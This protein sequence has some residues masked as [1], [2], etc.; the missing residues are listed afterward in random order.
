MRRED[1]WWVHFRSFPYGVS[2]ETYIP[3]V[4]IPPRAVNHQSELALRVPHPRL[5]R[6]RAVLGRYENRFIDRYRVSQKATRARHAS[7]NIFCGLKDAVHHE[8]LYVDEDAHEGETS[9]V[10][11]PETP[12]RRLSDKWR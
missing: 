11:V 8:G 10:Q 3:Y 2:P 1:E 9:A 4:R 5:G 6:G 7:F 12:Q